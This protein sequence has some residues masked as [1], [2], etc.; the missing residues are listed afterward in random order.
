MKTMTLVMEVMMEI[1]KKKRIS[2]KTKEIS[3]KMLNRI[4]M[5]EMMILTVKWMSK[6][7]ILICLETNKTT[8]LWKKKILLR[9]KVLMKCLRK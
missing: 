7:W 8:N 1:L 3:K 5:K 6:K 4:K 9:K 2:D